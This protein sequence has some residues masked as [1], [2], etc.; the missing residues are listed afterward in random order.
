MAQVSPDTIN[1]SSVRGAVCGLRLTAKW[2]I[3]STSTVN[4]IFLRRAGVSFRLGI[5]SPLPARSAGMRSVQPREVLEQLAL[6]PGLS[7]P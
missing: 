1:S 6:N 3:G 5:R 7:E 4:A 2:C